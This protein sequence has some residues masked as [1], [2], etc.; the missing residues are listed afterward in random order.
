MTREQKL[1]AIFQAMQDNE[2]LLILM[3]AII[4]K[5]LPNVS[6]EALDALIILLG[7]PNG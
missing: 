3:R 1:A 4:N 7:V 5:N 6:D 2:K